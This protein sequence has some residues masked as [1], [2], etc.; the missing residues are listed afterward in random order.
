MLLSIITINYNNLEGLKQ[1]ALSVLEQTCQSF[2]WIV[3]DGDSTDGSKE[4]LQ[5]ILRND[6]LIVS[7]P[8]KGIYDAQNKGVGLSHGEYCLFLNSGDSFANIEATAICLHQLEKNPA[9][10]FLRFAAI[11]TKNN[12]T[13]HIYTPPHEITG[14]FLYESFI[15]HQA[16]LIRRDLLVRVPYDI[17]YKIA[18]DADFFC[19][20]FFREKVQDAYCDIPL[21]YFDCSGVSSTEVAKTEEERKRLLLSTL[22][23][24]IYHDYR[25]FSVGRTFLEHCVTRLQRNAFFKVIA[26]IA[27]LPIY[28]CHGVISIFSN[29]RYYWRK[30]IQLSK[31]K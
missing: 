6:T 7:E 8:D 10:D 24:L 18:A 27:I 4:Y 1:T 30:L 12:K 20:C 22:G 9:C 26:E 28:A 19:K 13:C 23:E 14:I 31:H 3:V 25:R 5:A 15:A 17:S 29:T 21:T 16:T 2:E 11:L